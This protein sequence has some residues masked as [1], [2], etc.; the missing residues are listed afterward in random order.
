[1]V[2]ELVFMGSDPNEVQERINN[3]AKDMD[4][5]LLS[6]KVEVLDLGHGDMYFVTVT[7]KAKERNDNNEN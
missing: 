1:M 3:F 5:T 4:V 7:Y 2:G 6:G